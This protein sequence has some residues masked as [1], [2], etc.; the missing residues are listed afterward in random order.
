LGTKAELESL[1]NSPIQ[2][3]KSNTVGLGSKHSDRHSNYQHATGDAG[4]HT[5][6]AE[7]P[8]QECDEECRFT[9]M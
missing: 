7:I 6:N 2:L 4:E 1:W 9:T 3:L 5:R 8:Q